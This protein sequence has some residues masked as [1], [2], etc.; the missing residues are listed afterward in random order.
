MKKMRILSVLLVMAIALIVTGCGGGGG[1]SVPVEK[2]VVGIT[3]T[4]NDFMA[5][6]RTNDQTKMKSLLSGSS[7][8][9]LKIMDFGADLLDPSDNVEHI[10]Y[11]HPEHITQ[12]SEDVA[13]VKA[14]YLLS[15]GEYL[16]LTFSMVR[17]QGRWMIDD[18]EITDPPSSEG[19]VI[20]PSE[21]VI[22]TYNP[23]QTGITK[24][25]SLEDSAG[26]A[27]TTRVISWYGPGS[28]DGDITFHEF[29]EYFTEPADP[30]YEGFIPGSSRRSLHSD[31]LR[32][33]QNSIRSSRISLRA[34]SDPLL[35]SGGSVYYGFDSQGAYY[36]KMYDSNGAEIFNNG[37]PIKLFE[38]THA[39][40]TKRTISFPWEIDGTVFNATITI[41]IGY[42]IAN[43]ATPLGAYT[44]VQLTTIT[45]IDDSYGSGGK[46]SEYLVPNFG[47]VAYDDYDTFEATTP[48][49]RDRLLTRFNADGSLNERNDPVITNSANLGSY[50]YTQ[51]I[52][53]VQFN[54]TG[55]SAPFLYRS[56]SSASLMSGLSMTDAGYLS[57]YIGEDVPLGQY[58]FSIE[59]VDKYGRNSSK[60]FVFNIVDSGVGPAGG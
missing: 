13:F 15:S 25:M 11:V 30:D 2:D 5:A 41:D 58:Y 32:S 28:V 49:E 44:A 4:L 45:T 24:I 57:G 35:D 56:Y 17:D 52:T 7:E 27:S 12:P 54:H 20:A 51:T 55:G 21:F 16:W 6:A 22:A 39:Y 42:P 18:I 36:M 34:Q 10:F 29:F 26:N 48:I 14:S 40:G 19:G 9:S 38:P 3:N 37:Y 43:F 31:I 8:S 53:P 46:W 50:Y 1:S 23:I 60:Q 47:E 59:I 33:V